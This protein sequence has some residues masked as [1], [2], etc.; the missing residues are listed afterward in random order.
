MEIPRHIFLVPALKSFNSETKTKVESHKCFDSVRQKKP[1]LLTILSIFKSSTTRKQKGESEVSSSLVVKTVT[2][3]TPVPAIVITAR[4]TQVANSISTKDATRSPIVRCQLASSP[5]QS[6]KGG[7]SPSDSPR[8][9]SVRLSMR[10]PIPSSKAKASREPS[11][12]QN[13]SLASSSQ[14]TDIQQL[15]TPPPTPPLE[16]GVP[17]KVIGEMEKPRIP[18]SSSM[19][20]PEATPITRSKA[21]VFISELKISPKPVHREVRKAPTNTLVPKSLSKVVQISLAG[22]STSPCGRAPM[23]KT[24]VTSMKLVTPKS[25]FPTKAMVARDA[26][27]AEEMEERPIPSVVFQQNG[28]GEGV[29]VIKIPQENTK[30]E[31]RSADIIVH[32]ITPKASERKASSPL[33]ETTKVES[34]AK[35]IGKIVASNSVVSVLRKPAS[36]RK[37][38]HSPAMSELQDVLERR[39]A[40]M[41]SWKAVEPKQLEPLGKESRAPA[42]QAVAGTGSNIQARIAKI[43]ATAGVKALAQP[44]VVPPGARM[45]QFKR[46]ELLETDKASNNI[47]IQ[48]E[49]EAL[50]TMNKVGA[51][52]A[53]IVKTRAFGRT[54]AAKEAAQDTQ[55]ETLPLHLRN[56]S[57]RV[58]HEHIEKLTQEN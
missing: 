21:M 54:E 2:A 43:Y 47:R 26:N 24:Q 56:V 42:A 57:E 22:K 45:R 30:V 51:G 15:P 5:L 41:S 40:A 13:I 35:K 33:E 6:S 34:T 50:R 39:K 58:R 28:E 19:I 12:R 32:G 27:Q 31:V 3:S 25:S 11:A 20:F 36:P 38:V 46:P 7:V 16:C 18:R 9:S 10:V 17:M 14:T 53:A 44:I 37:A 52:G 55:G 48:R 23:V 29:E 49:I 8:R 4:K 1:K